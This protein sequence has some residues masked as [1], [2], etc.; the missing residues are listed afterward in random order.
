MESFETKKLLR[1]RALLFTQ[2]DSLESAKR[3]LLTPYMIDFLYS[4]YFKKSQR[5]NIK[6]LKYLLNL[7]GTYLLVSFFLCLVYD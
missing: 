7:F 1:Q 2:S 4:K 3:I 5:K 6:K